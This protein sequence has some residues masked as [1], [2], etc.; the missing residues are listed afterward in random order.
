MITQVRAHRFDHQAAAGVEG[1]RRDPVVELE[2]AVAV[3][4]FSQDVA[5]E[6]SIAV[7]QMRLDPGDRR[8]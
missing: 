1:V 7:W 3:G 4:I 2:N 5:L 8:V 6:G